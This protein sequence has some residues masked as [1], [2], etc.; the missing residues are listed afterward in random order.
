M[1]T[2]ESA[3]R[4]GRS[5]SRPGD[6]RKLVIGGSGFLGSHVTRELVR[7][8]Y[9]VRVL[10]RHTSSTTGIDDLDVERVY[11]DILDTAAVRAAMAGCDVVFHCAVDTRAW[12]RDPTP[13]FRTNVEGLRVVLDA[14]VEA[15][16]DRFVFTSTLGTIGLSSDGPATEETTHDWFETAG[17]YIRSR[18]RAESLVLDYVRQRGLPAVVMC[19]ANTY[20]PGDWAPTPH[21]GLL[22]A[23]ARGRMPAYVKGAAAEVVGVV[24]AARAMV[25]AAERGRVGHRYIVAERFMS[26]REIYRIAAEAGGVAPPRWAVPLA[27]MSVLGVLGEMAGRVFDRDVRLTRTSVRLMHIMPP[28]DHSKATRELGWRPG[29]APEAVYEAARFFVDERPSIR[30]STG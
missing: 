9:H 23:A 28:M 16:L 3:D 30:R 12:L 11:G 17:A 22:A 7:Q 24:D 4:T 21:G 15:D 13:L 27:V 26:S 10:L 5:R 14:A 1:S 18:V 2:P 25:L 6:A 20:G 19:V 29:P 8:G